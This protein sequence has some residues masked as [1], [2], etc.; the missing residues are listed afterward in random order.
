MS[1]QPS[2]SLYINP[3]LVLNYRRIAAHTA[4][5]QAMSH[6][7]PWKTLPLVLNLVVTH[8][9]CSI[10]GI[11][12]NN[13]VTVGPT[14]SKRAQTSTQAVR[15]PDK[16]RHLNWKY[17]IK[18]THVNIRIQLLQV[19]VRWCNFMLQNKHHLDQPSYS[20]C[21][22]KVPDIAFYRPNNQRTR[23]GSCL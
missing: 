7:S 20:C 1:T 8:H 6:A 21:R 14:K 4:T 11:Y 10:L 5:Q 23:S 22:F 2:Y 19:Q 15:V 18:F 12:F 17:N 9:G 13:N 16:F 3:F